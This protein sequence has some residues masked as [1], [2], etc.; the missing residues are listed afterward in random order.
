MEGS[1]DLEP[2]FARPSPH[3]FFP[4]VPSFVVSTEQSRAAEMARKAVYASLAVLAAV[5]LALSMPAGSSIHFFASS[6][7]A[8]S[9]SGRRCAKNVLSSWERLQLLRK[10]TRRQ[11]AR[12]RPT[13]PTQCSS[14][15]LLG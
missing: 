7:I 15:R 12:P 11:K 6:S 13:S 3:S 5:A 10:A 2:H 14:S 8:S 1:D 9:V 4:S